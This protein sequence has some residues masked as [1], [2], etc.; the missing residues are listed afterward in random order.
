[1]NPAAPPDPPDSG[2]DVTRHHV[3]TAADQATE[4]SAP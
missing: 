4:G 1:M 2:A 3:M